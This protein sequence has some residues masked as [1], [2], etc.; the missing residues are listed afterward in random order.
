MSSNAKSF[1]KESTTN[2]TSAIMP[3]VPPM[4]QQYPML[5]GVL[6]IPNNQIA[7]EEIVEGDRNQDSHQILNPLAGHIDVPS[8]V[9]FMYTSDNTITQ[10]YTSMNLQHNPASQGQDPPLPRQ[11]DDH[12][13]L[14]IEPEGFGFNPRQETAKILT[15][16]IGK[17][18]NDAY[19]T[20]GKIPQT[21]RQQIFNEFKEKCVW[22]PVHDKQIAINFEK[23]AR[24]RIADSF[25][26]GRKKGKIPKWCKPNI[27]EDLC[28][29]W[30]DHELFKK[31][32]E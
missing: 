6:L 22:L 5:F 15:S 23:R 8:P 21:V 14:I 12:Q 2:N 11:V 26:N 27:W 29:K 32:S 17:V 13:R 24:H 16:A 3:V 19:L 1:T 30:S 9:S 25:Y 31:R 20:W 28:Q 10:S 7:T 18:F 4:Q